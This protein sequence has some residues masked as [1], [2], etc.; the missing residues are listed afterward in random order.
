MVK[1]SIK[2]EDAPYDSERIWTTPVGPSLYRL[3]NSPFFAYGVSYL[4][5]V[6]AQSEV[7]GELPIFRKVIQKSGHRTLR[8]ITK[9]EGNSIIDQVKVFGASYEGFSPSYFSVDI[10]PEGNFIGL[11]NFLTASEIEWE[12]ADPNSSELSPGEN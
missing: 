12:H 5:I 8:L 4:D 1:I 9:K 11:C 2:L 10:T 6:E 7:P 3:E